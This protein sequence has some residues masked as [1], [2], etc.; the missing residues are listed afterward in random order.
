[1]KDRVGNSLPIDCVSHEDLDL[2]TASLQSL[3]N[4]TTTP[5][6][7]D[8]WEALIDTV[9]KAYDHPIEAYTSFVALYNMPSRW[10]H[11]EFQAF[12][13]PVNSVAQI[14]QIHFVALQAILTPILYLERIG[15][16][17]IN[18]PTA[19]MNWIEGVYMSLPPCYRV[20]VVWP[21]EV[22]RYFNTHS[23]GTVSAG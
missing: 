10:T 17:G 19:V 20:Y 5:C 11:D 3:E 7:R 13:N 4:L 21:I 23:M 15:F 1:M 6:E 14:L 8:Y 9:R 12:I 2:A 18:A 16:E 22:S